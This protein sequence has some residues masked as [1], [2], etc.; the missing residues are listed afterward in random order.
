MPADGHHQGKE[1]RKM[2]QAEKEQ[3]ARK[4]FFLY[5]R[6]SVPVANL[7][8]RLLGRIPKKDQIQVIRQEIE[9]S[10]GYPETTLLVDALE[11]VL[12]GDEIAFRK[13][14]R[15]LYR[16]L[17]GPELKKTVRLAPELALGILEKV[18]HGW[19]WR[20]EFPKPSMLRVDAGENFLF[21][22][23]VYRGLDG[24]M[25]QGVVELLKEH[26]N[27]EAENWDF[28]PDRFTFWIRREETPED[29]SSI[30]ALAKERLSSISPREGSAQGRVYSAQ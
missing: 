16:G 23:E 25:R 29:L 22:C 20:P 10:Q 13:Y 8:N 27:S 17:C 28:D 15:D 2:R 5:G 24:R 12:G 9:E 11:R 26:I 30:L 3:E 4:S 7:L 21:I 19:G 1:E 14:L 6:P 18:L